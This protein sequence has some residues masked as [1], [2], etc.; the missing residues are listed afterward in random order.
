MTDKIQVDY[1]QEHI[2]I[3]KGQIADN[4][5]RMIEAIRKV[6]DR[7]WINGFIWGAGYFTAFCLFAEAMGQ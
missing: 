7:S 6:K 5:Q 4:E 3:L 1:M 2:D